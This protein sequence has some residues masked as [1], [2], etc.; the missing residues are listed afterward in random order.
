MPLYTYSCQCG[1]RFE[2]I[3]R[4]SQRDDQK[5]P[6]CGVKATR[7]EIEDFAIKSTIN[8]KDKV[9]QTGKEIDLV[10]GRDSDQRWASHEER[11]RERR[12]GMDVVVPNLSEAGQS[13]NPEAAI[14]DA[15]RKAAADVYAQAYK[16]GDPALKQEWIDKVAPGDK[17]SGLKKI[18]K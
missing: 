6:E 17:N 1:A 14:G 18:G 11:T 8:P 3:S 10:V 9:I 15:N 12:K 7:S 2:R 16:A 13:F 5:C 4:A